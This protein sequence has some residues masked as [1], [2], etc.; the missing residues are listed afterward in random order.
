MNMNQNNQQ[1]QGGQQQKPG[2]Q[3]QQGV[4]RRLDAVGC[5]VA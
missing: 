5:V 1:G 4:E 2:Q 3:D